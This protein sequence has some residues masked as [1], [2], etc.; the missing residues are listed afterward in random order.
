MFKNSCVYDISSIFNFIS[1]I[2]FLIFLSIFLVIFILDF[3]LIFKSIEV[4]LSVEIRFNHN[5]SY[6]RIQHRKKYLSTFLKYFI[7]ELIGS[8]SIIGFGI[9]FSKDFLYDQVSLT[10]EIR[11]WLY[12][13][14]SYEITSFYPHKTLHIFSNNSKYK[15]LH[16]E[17]HTWSKDEGLASLNE[18]LNQFIMNSIFIP[19]LC[20]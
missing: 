6:L 9:V 8:F 16:G 12:F 3:F 14:F 15:K 2:N 10:Y 7:F 5:V 20:K 19:L 13:I 11:S 1:I 17:H 18:N 4:G